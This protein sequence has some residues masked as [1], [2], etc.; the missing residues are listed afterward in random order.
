MEKVLEFFDAWVKSQKEFMEN[1]VKSQ[2]E[3]MENWTEATKKMQESF[4]GI[5]G[6]QEGPAKEMQNLYNSWVNTMVN[7]SKSFSAEAAKIQEAWKN[8]FEKQLEMS[9]EMIKNFSE[10]FKQKSGN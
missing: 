4:T 5:G 8:T 1:W 6:S 7:S 3:F 9:R 2:K 10:L